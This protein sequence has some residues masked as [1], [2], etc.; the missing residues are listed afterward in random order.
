MALD[1]ITAITDLFNG[2]GSKVIERIWPDPQQAQ[3]AKIKLAEM[4]QNGELAKIASEADVTKA[5][6]ADTQSARSRDVAIIQAK[7][8][9]LRG[10]VLAYGALG[11]LIV[12]ILI[13]FLVHNIPETSEKL[14]YVVLGAL[15][16]IVKDVFSF[17][18]G[19][20]K[21]SQRNAQ[22]VADMLK[23]GQ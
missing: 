11:A 8:K 19:S 23:N 14:L 2:I 6:L 18:F 13:L 17:E 20:S 12:T 7:G 4:A 21:D 1:P 10:D 15:I 3:E 5:F 9:N 22:A 16:T